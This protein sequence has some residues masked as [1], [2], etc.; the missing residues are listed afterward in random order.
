M[1]KIKSLF[2]H[3]GIGTPD[4]INVIVSGGDWPALASRWPGDEHHCRYDKKGFK[5]F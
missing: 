3:N 5:R 1:A 2:Y 4:Q